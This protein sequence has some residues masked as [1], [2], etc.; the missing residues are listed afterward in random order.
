MHGVTTAVI[1]TSA[2]SYSVSEFKPK[3]KLDP[4]L[5]GENRTTDESKADIYERENRTTGTYTS[6]YAAY[7]AAM[8]AS[9]S[10]QFKMRIV[11]DGGGNASEK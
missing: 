4:S 3:R 9:Y 8:K 5:A 7:D 1:H 11:N 10:G 2:K 6:K